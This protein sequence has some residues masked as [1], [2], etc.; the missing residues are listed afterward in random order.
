MRWRVFFRDAYDAWVKGFHPSLDEESAM[1]A[2]LEDLEESGPPP[3]A[4]V[5]TVSRAVPKATAGRTPQQA[6]EA[7]PPARRRQRRRASRRRR[8]RRQERRTAL[9]AGA[10]SSPPRLR[11]QRPCAAIAERRQP[12]ARPQAANRRWRRCPTAR[13][14]RRRPPRPLRRTRIA[15]PPAGALGPLQAATDSNPDKGP[16]DAAAAMAIHE[17]DRHARR[18]HQARIDQSPKLHAPVL[19]EDTWRRALSTIS[20]RTLSA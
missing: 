5:R 8:P 2:W 1:V 10:S 14:T 6:A 18:S 9:E 17:T 20:S 13:A 19:R 11:Q 12:S 16:L 15:I 3:V 4:S 7:G